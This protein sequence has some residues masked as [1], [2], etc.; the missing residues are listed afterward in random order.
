M[1]LAAKLILLFLVGILLIVVVFSI[2]TLQRERQIALEQHQR[3]AE[4][5]AEIIQQS[6]MELDSQPAKV[7]HVRVRRVQLT[8]SDRS[9]LPRVP[10]ERLTVTEHI[11]T[12]SMPDE[13]GTN[14]LYTY[15]PLFDSTGPAGEPSPSGSRIEISAP[16]SSGESHL[17]NALTTSL[18]TLVGVSGLSAI[19]IFVGGIRMVGR[20]LDRLIAKV[21]RVSRGDFAGPVELNS[22]DELGKL[23]SAVNQMC[24]RLTQQREQLEIETAHRIDALE[25]LRHADRLRSVGRIAAGIAHEIGTPLNVVSGRAELIASGDLTPQGTRESALAIKTESDRISRTISSLLEFARQRRPHREETNLT[26]L[27]STTIGLLRPLAEK[28]HAELRLDVPE[29]AVMAEIDQAQMQQVVT[30]LINN[31]VQSDDSGVEVVISLQ[32][33][34]DKFQLTVTDNGRG[35]DQDTLSHLFEP[36]F[37]TK[38]VGEGNGL[39]LAISHGIVSEHGGEITVDSTPGS[40]PGHGS[41]FL[42]TVPKRQMT[43]GTIRDSA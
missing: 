14:R 12:I 10:V 3:Y 20:P 13:Q 19:V 24:E 29:Q 26:Q 31:A 41:T 43:Q 18:L 2:I 4:D 9:H 38:P 27:L 17:Q 23:G 8:T 30:N 1:R 7:R 34:G 28:S 15:V 25:Q 6:A 11:T 39:G 37:T 16:D 42:V 21:G 32:D 22:N 40:A 5:L 33:R 35:M 36:F